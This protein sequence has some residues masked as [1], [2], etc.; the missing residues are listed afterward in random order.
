MSHQ[1]IHDLGSLLQTTEAVMIKS[2]KTLRAV[3]VTLVFTILSVLWIAR[4]EWKQAD[5]EKRISNNEQDTKELRVT[6]YNIVSDVSGIKGRLGITKVEIPKRA[7]QAWKGDE[8]ET[9]QQ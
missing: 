2:H 1:E 5:H 6:T 8:T 7:L 3:Y 4:A 9:T